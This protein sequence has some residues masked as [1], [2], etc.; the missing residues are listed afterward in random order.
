MAYIWIIALIAIALIDV[1][2]R[3]WT[4]LISQATP[5]GT[6]TLGLA[7]IVAAAAVGLHEARTQQRLPL[8]TIVSLIVAV[9]GGVI[10]AALSGMVLDPILRFLNLDDVSATSRDPRRVVASVTM[11]LHALLG[12]WL[13]LRF[14]HRWH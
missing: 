13:G 7:M 3:E 14:A 4:G 10:A 2:I 1:L 6:V 9:G 11:M 8:G 12:A 5:G